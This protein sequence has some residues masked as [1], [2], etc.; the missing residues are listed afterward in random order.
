[1][2]II[3]NIEN[4]ELE[5]MEFT[6]TVGE[7]VKCYGHLGNSLVISSKIKHKITILPSNFSPRYLSKRNENICPHKH[8]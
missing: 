8:L 5:K 3:K 6:Y 4:E 2:V 1:M 7:N